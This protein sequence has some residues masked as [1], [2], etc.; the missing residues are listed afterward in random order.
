LHPVISLTASRVYSYKFL[1][2]PTA[3]SNAHIELTAPEPA[4]EQ[5]LHLELT[6]Q[7]PV[8]E[9]FL[10][11]SAHSSRASNR[12]VSAIQWQSMGISHNN[13]EW[14]KGDSKYPFGSSLSPVLD[15]IGFELEK[16]SATSI[17]GRFVVSERSAQSY[18]VLHGGISAFLAESLGSLGAIIASGFQQVAGVEVSTS[19]LQPA[20]VGMEIEVKA[21]PI[22]IGRRLQVWEVKLISAK[23]SHNDL[24]KQ[25]SSK[26]SEPGLIALSKLTASVLSSNVA[27]KSQDAKRIPSRL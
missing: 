25:D 5:F 13:L 8:I 24:P 18:G 20:P 17:E 23:S 6:A 7:E 9:Q 19:H 2:F 10:Q 26:T 12:T 14:K 3:S 11:F 27:A 4:I 15:F 1:Q 22:H 21:T 16:A